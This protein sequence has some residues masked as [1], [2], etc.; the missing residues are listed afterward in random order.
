MKWADEDPSDS[1]VKG[2]GGGHQSRERLVLV[3][4]RLRRSQE[5]YFGK[6]RSPPQ[7]PSEVAARAG[8]AVWA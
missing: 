2:A 3:E 6:P 4:F 1:G 5:W 7:S 8:G